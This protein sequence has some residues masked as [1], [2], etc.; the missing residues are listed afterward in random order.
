V[1]YDFDRNPPRR[2]E[3]FWAD[4]DPARGSEQGGHRPVLIISPDGFNRRMRV[5]VTVALTSTVR[6]SVRE[7]RSPV[8]VFLPAGE[9]LESEGSVLAFQVTTLARER[10]EDKAGELTKEQMRQV[11]HAVAMSFGLRLGS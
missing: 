9:P 8:S 7:G 6:D 10:L 5:V 2:G 1:P 4:L 3:I 11:D